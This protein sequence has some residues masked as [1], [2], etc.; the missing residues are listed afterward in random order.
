MKTTATQLRFSN[1]DYLRPGHGFC[2]GCGAALALRYFLKAVGDKL[3]LISPPGCTAPS[4]SFPKPTLFGGEMGDT[5]IDVIHCPFGSAAIFAGGIKAGLQDRGDDE[6][7][8]VA[9]A[10]D[11]ATF[12]I[13]FGA[14][15]GA[16]QRNEDIIYVCYDNEAYVNT[17]NQKSGATPGGART[18][19]DL[20]PSAEH[21]KKDLFWSMLGQGIPYLATATVAYPQDLMNKAAKAAAASGFRLLHILTPCIPAWS[22][23][24]AASVAVS[25]LA[26][27]TRYFPLLEAENGGAVRMKS[28]VKQVDAA[29][30]FKKQRRFAGMSQEDLAKQQERIDARWE[31]LSRLTQE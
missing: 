2:P 3:V 9:W 10:G 14:L 16:A 7:L 28:N 25:R 13:G 18:T 4:I 6:T 12:D 29:E 23:D 15:A 24:P 1:R 19:T 8:V 21:A 26:V 27:Q 22:I 31:R 17:G 20:A 11:G 30:F 5:P